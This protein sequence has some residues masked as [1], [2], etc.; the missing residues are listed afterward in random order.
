M[1]GLL[2]ALCVLFFSLWAVVVVHEGLARF[3]RHIAGSHEHPGLA[4]IV[5]G[6]EPTCTD[7]PSNL[8]NHGVQGPG[9]K[10][11]AAS[12]S[13]SLWGRGLSHNQ[14][15]LVFTTNPLRVTDGVVAGPDSLPNRMSADTVT[16]AGTAPAMTPACPDHPVALCVSRHAYDRWQSPASGIGFFGSNGVARDA[17]SA[18]VSTSSTTGKC[19]WHWHPHV[20]TLLRLRG[21]PGVLTVLLTVLS[22]TKSRSSCVKNCSIHDIY[23]AAGSSCQGA[24]SQERVLKK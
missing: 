15:A 2:V 3:R 16:A 9:V 24:G 6:P 18:A 17:Q 13:D 8:A 10:A 23:G 20:A 4:D 7:A 5:A 12:G 1:S 19:H 14:A 22:L 11:F 21:C